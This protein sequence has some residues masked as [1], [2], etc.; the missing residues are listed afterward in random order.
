VVLRKALEEISDRHVARMSKRG[1]YVRFWRET[2]NA[3]EYLEERNVGGRIIL[4][5]SQRNRMKWYG[6]H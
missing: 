2:Q 6:L 1:M 4:S 3:R 5:G